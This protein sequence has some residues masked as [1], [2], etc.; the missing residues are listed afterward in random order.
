[1]KKIEQILIKEIGPETKREEEQ[2]YGV[3]NKLY[4][5]LLDDIELKVPASIDQADRDNSLVYDRFVG[6]G[7]AFIR[8]S[9]LILLGAYDASSR[10]LR[11]ILE[12]MLNAYN[13]DKEHPETEL[14]CKL[15][16]I[17][18]TERRVYGGRLIEKSGLPKGKKDRFN[19]LY[20]NLCG[21]IHVSHKYDEMK[22]NK[23]IPE[24]DKDL[25]GESLNLVKEVFDACLYIFLMKFS[26]PKPTF[27]KKK[28]LLK[29]NQFNLTLEILEEA[30][31]TS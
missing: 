5:N 6:L 19:N 28:E 8:C 3:L 10:E 25:F 2:K 21:Y 12:S 26:N 4:F 15:E 22:E 30:P 27:E 29:D 13:L 16:I 31:M 9:T 23:Y 20:K 24:F 17:K 18:A 1:M 7:F 11:F 14:K